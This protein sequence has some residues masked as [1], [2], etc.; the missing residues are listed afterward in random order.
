MVAI[1]FFFD[2]CDYVMIV[3]RF[4]FIVVSIII[5]THISM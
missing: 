1:F 3:N 2:K 4:E 5:E